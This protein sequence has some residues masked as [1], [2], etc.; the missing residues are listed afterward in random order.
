MGHADVRT[1]MN[2]YVEVT[3]KLKEREF[4]RYEKYIMSMNEIKQNK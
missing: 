1:T 2:I 4:E 3:N